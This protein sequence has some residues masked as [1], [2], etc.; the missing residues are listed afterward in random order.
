MH[1]WA[2]EKCS[3]KTPGSAHQAGGLW[4]RPGLQALV[5]GTFRCWVLVP[6]GTPPYSH[7]HDQIYMR[8]IFP[9]KALLQFTKS[10]CLRGPFLPF[11]LQNGAAS[12]GPFSSSNGL[13][14][15]DLFLPG[16]VPRVEPWKS[17]KRRRKGSRERLKRA[18]GP[19]GCTAVFTSSSLGRVT[20]LLSRHTARGRV[21]P[22]SPE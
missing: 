18:P 13:R 22:I 20:V 11:T 15:C 10:H 9:C 19:A 4:W 7:R 12:L 5:C 21:R 1:Y 2:E 14:L 3:A 8:T 6:S 16:L 17:Q